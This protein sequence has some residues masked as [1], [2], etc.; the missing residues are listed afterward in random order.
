VNRG[1]GGQITD[2]M[3]ARVEADV[4]ALKPAAMLLL[5]GTNDV[6]RGVPLDIVENNLKAM[7]ELAQSHAIKPLL[8]SVLPAGESRPDRPPQTVLTLNSWI[9]SLCAQRNY[10]YVDYFTAMTGPSGRL[11]PDLSDDGLHPNS[12]GYRIMAPIALAAIEK[13]APSPPPPKPKHRVS[14][15]P[16]R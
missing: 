7:A 4:I 14:L 16:A 2:E 5:G 11:R 6:A 9:K 13:A 10:I 15:L 3:L 12:L 1:I 8:A